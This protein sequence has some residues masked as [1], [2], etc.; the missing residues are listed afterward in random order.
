MMHAYSSFR[1]AEFARTSVE[2]IPF[3][4]LISRR[5]ENQMG[6]PTARTTHAID[7]LA[8]AR[9]L[10]LSLLAAD[11]ELSEWDLEALQLILDA[12]H[13]V[14]IIDESQLDAVSYLRTGALNPH[15]LTRRE[16]LEAQIHAERAEALEILERR[17]LP[18]GQ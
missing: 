8:A 18:M 17:A 2:P 14:M 4:E 16:R 13:D 5:E 3:A 11:G 9:A 10:L 1:D 7:K 15:R 6:L 12:K